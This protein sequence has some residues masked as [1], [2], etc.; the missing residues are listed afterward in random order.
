MDWCV[1][2]MHTMLYMLVGV[3]VTIDCSCELQ[4]PMKGTTN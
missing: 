3:R 1:C 2:V 4:L